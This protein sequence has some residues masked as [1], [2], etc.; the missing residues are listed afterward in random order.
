MTV[1]ESRASADQR[2]GRAARLGPGVAVRCFAR[3]EW[4]GMSAE[5]TAEASV[6]DLAGAALTL[7]CW[8]SARGQGMTLPD[9][10][11]SDALDRAIAT[12]RGLGALDARERPTALGRRLSTLP[13]DPRLGRA[14]LVGAAASARPAPGR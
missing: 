2:A 3:D 13:L 9:P 8:G 7:A 11:P 6:S 10:L 12:L 5:A 1:R 14:L 4:A